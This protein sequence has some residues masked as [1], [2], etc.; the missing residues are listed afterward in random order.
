MENKPEDNQSTNE[1]EVNKAEA[2]AAESSESVNEQSV[3]GETVSEEL[4]STRSAK[5]HSRGGGAALFISLLA[6]LAVVGVVM[7]GYYY[8][9]NIDQQ[10]ASLV[11]Q[12]T[13]VTQQMASLQAMESNLQDQQKS[14]QAAKST[15]NDLHR[16]VKDTINTVS[17]NS[18]RVQAL[19]SADRSDWQLAEAEYL[20]RLASQRLLLSHDVAS[21]EALLQSADKLIAEQNDP[22]LFLAR[23]AIAQDITALRLAGSIDREGVYLQLQSI[24]E[25]LPKLKDLPYIDDSMSLLE[26]NADNPEWK[27]LLDKLKEALGIHYRHDDQLVPPLLPPAERN[28]VLLN[29]R[30][31]LEQA[32]LALLQGEQKLYQESLRRAEE[33]VAHYFSDIDPMTDTLVTELNALQQLV[34]VQTLPDISASLDTLKAAIDQRHA[35]QTTPQKQGQ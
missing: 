14:L 19:S 32:Q 31:M 16:D 35:H 6:L 2:G 9:N 18:Q 13:K 1:L 24:I 4:P 29:L 11:N 27:V 15:L 23:K 22:K 12:Q 25:Q 17:S 30:F 20:L 10:V 33:W 8:A 3:D 26:E 7:A 21:A 34:V 5:S 28:I